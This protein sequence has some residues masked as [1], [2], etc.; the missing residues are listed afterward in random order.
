MWPRVEASSLARFLVSGKTALK[1][2]SLA[3]PPGSRLPLLNLYTILSKMKLSTQSQE[4][5]FGL[6]RL[7][8][9]RTKPARVVTDLS[10]M[11]RASMQ[12]R[13]RQQQRRASG[14]VDHW[15]NQGVS[16]RTGTRPARLFHLEEIRH[17]KACDVDRSAII[18]V[19]VVMADLTKHPPS[20]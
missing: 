11:T 5:S 6:R 13:R 18:P 7:K 8:E 1:T 14:R 3:P 12:A 15:L 16:H 20:P 9:S 10:R 19:A 2:S 4:N 17:A